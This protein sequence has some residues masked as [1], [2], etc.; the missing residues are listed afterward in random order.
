[1]KTVLVDPFDSFSHVIEQYLAGIGAEPVVVRSHPENPER[2]AAMNPDVLVL[3]PGPGHPLDSGHVELI[4][5]FENQIPI[6]GV[7]LGLQAIGCRYGATVS[8]A[9]HIMHGRTSPI[10]H[11][12]KGMFSKAR[13]EQVVTRYHSLIIEDATLPDELEVTSRST[14]DGYIMGVRHRSLPVEAV[15]FHPES[16][17]TQDGINL[18]A[19]FFETYVPGFRSAL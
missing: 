3:G 18:F 2:I 5:T 10:T 17:T 8:P 14:D 15:Q 6:M 19:G 9:S 13:A 7:C 12:G 16:I 4:K 11:D 1:M